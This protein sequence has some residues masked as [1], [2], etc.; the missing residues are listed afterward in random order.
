MFEKSREFLLRQNFNLG[1]R[2]K[3]F[4]FAI[5]I[6]LVSYIAYHHELWRDEVDVWLFVRDTD[7]AGYFRYLRNSGHPGLWHTLLLPFAKMHF[8]NFT[9]Q[10]IHI[11]IA[12][13][14]VYLS[15]LI[16]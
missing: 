16:L 2:S 9:I 6:L 11:S 12:I 15:F 3:Y 1:K 7:I 10:V 14:S 8:P 5:Y 4:F 13:V